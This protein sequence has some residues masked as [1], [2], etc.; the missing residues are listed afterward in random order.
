VQMTAP[1]HREKL[2]NRE[3]GT[4]DKIDGDGNLKLKHGLRPRGRVQRGSIRIWTTAM[5]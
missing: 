1:Y 5:R 3:L 4:V 2:A